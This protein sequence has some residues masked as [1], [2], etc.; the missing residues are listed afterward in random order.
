[1]LDHYCLTLIPNTMPVEEITR[2]KEKCNKCGIGYHKPSINIIKAVF[3]FICFLPVAYFFYDIVFFDFKMAIVNIDLLKTKFTTTEIGSIISY[4]KFHQL[5]FTLYGLLTICVFMFIF[6]IVNMYIK[7]KSRNTINQLCSDLIDKINV[8]NHSFNRFQLEDIYSNEDWRQFKREE[9]LRNAKK[10]ILAIGFNLS[11]TFNEEVMLNI[12][13]DKINNE[14]IKLKIFVGKDDAIDNKIYKDRLKIVRN[15]VRLLRR[16][17]SQDKNS[18]LTFTQLP[19]S[20]FDYIIKVDDSK[21]FIRWNLN[22][23]DDLS[24]KTGVM[25][26]AVKENCI[27]N[28]FIKPINKYLSKLE[29][30]K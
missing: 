7:R 27:E 20:N 12:L 29:G 22:F 13:K 2:I 24:N 11:H 6:I 10:E 18:N 16:Q 4:D 1:V 28:D 9:I 8:K 26:F 3:S 17:L 15:N 21:I 30:F 25:C 19:G 23:S 5:Q 14:N